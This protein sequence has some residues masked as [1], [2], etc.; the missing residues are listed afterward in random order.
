N[1]LLS[2]TDIDCDC[3]A[4]Y[5]S[6]NPTA[7]RKPRRTIALAQVACRAVGRRLRPSAIAAASDDGW[8]ATSWC[9][10]AADCPLPRCTLLPW[11]GSG[12][13]QCRSAP[14]FDGNSDRQAGHWL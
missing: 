1:V 13:V 11:H 8:Q 14:L 2:G 7:H 9:D 4:A 10:A 3:P 5:Q 6:T 12:P